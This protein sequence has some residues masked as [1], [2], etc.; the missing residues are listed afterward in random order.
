MFC[1]LFY[2]N[3]ST[4]WSDLEVRALTAGMELGSM[5][6]EEHLW[7]STHPPPIWC[8]YSPQYCA[9]R[10]VSKCTIIGGQLVIISKSLIASS[11]TSYMCNPFTGNISTWSLSLTAS[12]NFV[13]TIITYGFAGNRLHNCCMTVGKQHWNMH[14]SHAAFIQ[15][16]NYL[17]YKIYDTVSSWKFHNDQKVVYS[18]ICTWTLPPHFTVILWKEG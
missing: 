18:I 13:N 12:I 15:S 17:L 1:I 4:C 14:V 16:C 9:L 3:S 7:R 8:M 10:Q 11:W 2:T 6:H 5:Q